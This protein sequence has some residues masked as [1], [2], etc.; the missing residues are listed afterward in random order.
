MDIQT[1][2]L[3]PDVEYFI[4]C[5][6]EHEE[7]DAGT[8]VALKLYADRTSLRRIVDGE[9]RLGPET[10]RP[11]LQICAGLTAL[12]EEII[13][14]L[15]PLRRGA[16]AWANVR[17]LRGVV[18][19]TANYMA[20]WAIEDTIIGGCM[21]P[22]KKPRNSSEGR[23]MHAYELSPR[24][25][26]R[27]YAPDWIRRRVKL[28]DDAA[29]LRPA[30]SR[31]LTRIAGIPWATVKHEA[32]AIT[33]DIIAQHESY[34]RF[35]ERQLRQAWD[36]GRTRFQTRRTRKRQ[37]KVIARAM[38]CAE[39]VLGRNAVRHFVA[40]KPVVLMGDKVALEVSR[41]ASSASLGHM[42]LYVVAVDPASK[43]RLANLCV[44]HDQTPALDQLTA[45]ALGM[46]AGEEAEIMATANLSRV[47]ELGLENPLIAER[48]IAHVERWR[49]RDRK[50]ERNEAYWQATK[51]IW[52]ESLGVH[53]LGR[54]WSV[55]A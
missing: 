34:R 31:A 40:G 36:A 20:W 19:S 27:L 46:R 10:L 45:L 12:S 14:A 37:R 22:Y 18:L 26:R 55:A 32:D 3:I 29:R 53:T 17:H 47:S 7:I 25:K 42:G 15:P 52:L 24:Q 1:T 9:W 4:D 33:A 35:N 48:G 16:I 38:I 28:S 44:Y 11:R 8:H 39:S 49:P 54:V 2:P 43:R 23:R 21:E 41:N 50:Q 5:A 51:S 6:L 30:G 13:S